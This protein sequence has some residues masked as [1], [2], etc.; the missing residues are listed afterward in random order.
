MTEEKT[1]NFPDHPITVTDAT[2]KE[3]I[4]KYPLVLIDFWA[5]WC[6]PCKIVAPTVAEVA[7]DNAGKLV[8]GKVNVDENPNTSGAFRIMSIPTLML[9]K[10]GQ[11]VDTIIGALPKST[12][13]ERI[14]VHM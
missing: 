3:V 5:E 12:I 4:Q 14:K 13:E 2:F 1:A 6:H 8:C 11:P 9:F 10:K 7:K